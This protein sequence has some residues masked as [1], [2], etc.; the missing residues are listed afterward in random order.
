MKGKKNKINGLWYV[1]LMDSEQ[2]RQFLIAETTH[3]ASSVY[4][5]TTLVETIKFLHQYLFSPTVNT[6]CKAIDND[7][8]LGFPAITSALIHKYLPPSMATAKGHMNHT[9][10]GLRSTTKQAQDDTEDFNPK[11]DEKAN[12]ELFIGTT[13]VQQNDGT[14]CTNQTGNF[15][16]QS[17]HGKRCMFVAYKYRSNTIM[18]RVLCDQKDESLIKAFN[19][20]YE[21]FTA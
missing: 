14:I 7:H 11:E 19:S 17:N 21:H 6:L 18:V 9:G 1:P 16:V 15:P 2:E 20:V 5:T 12:V 8:F 4:H 13:I 10:K 3:M